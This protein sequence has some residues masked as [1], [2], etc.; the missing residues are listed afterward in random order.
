MFRYLLPSITAACMAA[1][2]FAQDM[3]KRAGNDYPTQAR[4][5]YVFSCMAV[6]GGT[7][8]ALV[9]CSCAIDVIA[10]ILPYEDYVTAE[11]VLRMRQTS[12]EK[13]ALFRGTEISN[14][15]VEELRRAQAEAEIR[16]F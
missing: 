9:K 15:A 14:K 13:S 11:T 6:N 12:G 2:A 3:N 4:A 7:Q 8:E 5:E 16:C 1:S 10:S